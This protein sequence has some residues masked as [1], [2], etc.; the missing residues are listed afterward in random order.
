MNHHRLKVWLLF[1]PFVV[2]AARMVSIAICRKVSEPGTIPVN[3]SDRFTADAPV[4]RIDYRV[5]I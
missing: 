4:K 3:I 1:I 5:E 2:Y